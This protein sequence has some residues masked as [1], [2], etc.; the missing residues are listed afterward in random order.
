MKPSLK[1]VGDF[2]MAEGHGHPLVR[3]ISFGVTT[4]PI[5]FNWLN[6]LNQ[7]YHSLVNFSSI[8]L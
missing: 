6:L 8:F 1:K 3:Q 4:R 5:G 2:T 7:K